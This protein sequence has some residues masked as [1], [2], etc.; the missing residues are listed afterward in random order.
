MRRCTRRRPQAAAAAPATPGRTCT[1]AAVA[2]CGGEGAAGGEETRD[3]G[4]MRAPVGLQKISSFSP[5]SRLRRGVGRG[6]VGMTL[7]T[8]QAGQTKIET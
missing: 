3:A 1:P 7:I 2:E 4:V 6:I 5:W 8:R